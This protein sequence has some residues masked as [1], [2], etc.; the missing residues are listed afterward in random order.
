MLAT[1]AASYGKIASASSCA[2]EGRFQSIV[3]DMF[4]WRWALDQ[5]SYGLMLVDRESGEVLCQEFVQPDKAIYPASTIK[6]LIAMAVLRKVDE[7]DLSLS[8]EVTITQPNAEQECGYW[9]CE[10]YGPG[11]KVSLERLIRDTITISNNIA[12]NQLVDVASKTLINGTADLLGASDIRVF[13]KVYDDVD[14]EPEIR[15]P[16]RATA[17][18]LARVYLEIATGRLGL[19]SEKSRELLIQVLGDQKYNGS[20]SGDF[21]EGVTFF[22]KTGST[23]KVT[24]DGGFFKVD[25]SRM[26]ILV[27]LQDFNRYRVCSRDRGCRWENGYRSLRM[28]GRKAYDLTR[29]LKFETGRN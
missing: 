3:Y 5:T 17:R 29:E 9:G 1:P 4:G 13:R 18:G 15:T 11:R 21:P 19:L 6:T 2:I 24:G 12:S 22:H 8:Q 14:P 28:I 7:G 25:Q 26:A 16:N 27:G 23:S 10:T 20:L